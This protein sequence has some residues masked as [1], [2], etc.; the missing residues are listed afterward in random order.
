MKNM[1]F[2]SDNDVTP[3]I[4]RLT[5]GAVMLP[6]GLQKL[7]GWFGGHGFAGTMD[8]FTGVMEFPALVAFLVI[9][10]ESFG[11]LGL[12]VGFMTRFCAIGIVMVMTGAIMMV[13]W[14]NGFFMNWSGQQAGEGFEYHLLAIA[15][16]FALLIK[17]GGAL[18][19]DRGIAGS[20]HR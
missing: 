11:A 10:A 5:L 3:L 1:I 6:H 18:S 7:M 19:I 9:A 14:K 17:G 12:I 2:G 20:R 13:H 8:Y 16:A 15:I 4:L